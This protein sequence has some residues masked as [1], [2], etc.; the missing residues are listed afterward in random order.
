MTFL[1]GMAATTLTRTMF[2]SVHLLLGY[3]PY[4]LPPLQ[5][6]NTRWKEL[7]F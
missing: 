2:S 7:L 1:N 6:P 5:E 4:E 3:N